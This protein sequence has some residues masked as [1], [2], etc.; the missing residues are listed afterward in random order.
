M[1][2]FVVRRYDSVPTVD[3]E[4]GQVAADRLNDGGQYSDVITQTKLDNNKTLANGVCHTQDANANNKL[5]DEMRKVG[6]SLETLTDDVTEGPGSDPNIEN[7]VARGRAFAKRHRQRLVN[8][9]GAI[10]IVKGGIT[11]RRRGFMADMFTTLL[12][13]PWR[14]IIMLFAAGFVISWM[15]FAII[16]YII[17]K[18]HGDDKHVDDPDWTMCIANVYDFPTALLFSIE[19][20]HTIG[21]GARMVES[22]CLEN[23][24]LLMMQSCIGVFIQALLAG[25]IFAKLS[26]PKKRSNTIMFSKNAVICK[27][28]G[29]LC[30]LFRLGDMRKSHIVGAT[31]R[32]VMVQNRCVCA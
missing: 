4:S 9:N 5:Q 28:D 32:A 30:L 17:M 25:L 2:T 31:I 16:W 20:Q 29:E 13:L 8:K 26:R 6:L 24:P 27:R 10:N 21:Y 22:K 11:D 14:Y 19:T 18:A 23:I 1:R 15:V 7:V 3:Q 12:D